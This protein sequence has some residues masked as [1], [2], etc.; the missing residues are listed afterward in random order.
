[1]SIEDT[2][3]AA[4]RAELDGRDERI[5]QRVADL[6]RA[7]MR[8]GDRLLGKHDDLCGYA[9]ETVK[10]MVADGRL[11]R[12]GTVRKVLVSERELR[13]LL[14]KRDVGEKT[15]ADIHDLAVARANRGRK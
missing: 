2:I 1:M 14:A 11:T 6:M 9:W 3:R 7:D 15:D 13:A 5:A 4:V 10:R 12:F 8:S